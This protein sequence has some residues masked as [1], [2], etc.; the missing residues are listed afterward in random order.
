ISHDLAVIRHVSHRVGVLYKG[1]MVEQGTTAEVTDNPR[2]PYT[3]RL[4]LAAPVADPD[5][6]A[7]RRA[8]RAEMLAT[9]R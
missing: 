5:R 2:N 9:D 3:Q 1:N 6:Q 7:E 4:I 8:R